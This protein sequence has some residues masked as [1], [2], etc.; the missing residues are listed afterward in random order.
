MTIDLSL[1]ASFERLLKLYPRGIPRR[2]VKPSEKGGV[3]FVYDGALIAEEGELLKAAVEK[4]LGMPFEESAH[5]S[6]QELDEKKAARRL[7]VILGDKAA[8][9]ASSKIGAVGG[10]AGQILRTAGGA[11]AILSVELGAVLKS[12]EIKKEFWRHLKMIMPRIGGRRP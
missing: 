2:L 12:P 3:L 1:P 6:V 7:L 8:A 9:A 5:C 11:E 10:S 4:G